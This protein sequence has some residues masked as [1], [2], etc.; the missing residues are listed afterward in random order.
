MEASVF[1]TLKN[2]SAKI[3]INSR[4]VM[5]SWGHLLSLYYIDWKCLPYLILLKFC[6]QK[7][8]LGPVRTRLTKFVWRQCQNSI[9]ILS[10]L[11]F[12]FGNRV[13]T[14]KD[15][16]FEQPKSV[17]HVENELARILW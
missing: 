13:R 5:I 16:I 7:N 2:K 3:Q 12:Q 4:T 10:S 17:H 15:Q 9:Q 1:I 14:Y 8:H 11:N 6:A